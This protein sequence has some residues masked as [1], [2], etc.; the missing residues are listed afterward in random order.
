MCGIVGIVGRSPVN[1]RIYD[2]LTMLQHRGQDAAGM[3]TGD[4]AR[5]HLRKSR[6]LVKEVFEQR[7]IDRLVGNVGIGHV[8]YPTAG[9]ASAAES[10]PMYVNFPYGITLA[11]NGNLTNFDGLK[12]DLRHE[13]RRHLNTDSDSELLLNAFAHELQMMNVGRPSADD[14]FRAVHN[15]HRRCQGA[16]AAVAMIVGV[17]IVSFRDPHGIRPLV[18]GRRP[19]EWGYEH[20]IASESVAL[21]MLGFEVV[22]DVAPGE[23]VFISEAGEVARQ[24][25][26]APATHSPCLFEYV[27]LARPDSILDGISVY[28][29]RLRMGEHLAKR[30]LERYPGHDH[31]IDVV[32]PIPDTSRTCA[33]PL[34]YEL[35]V[36]YREGFIKNRY[37]GR[38]FIM[39]GQ[40]MRQ[41]SVR[42]KLNAIGLEFKGKNVLL[43]DDSIVRGTTI[44]Q[45]V[46]MAREAGARRVYV[47]SAAPPIRYPN[48]YGIDMPAAAEL[49]A[50]RRSEDEVGRL[51]HAD[52]LAY[53]HL[54]DLIDSARAGNPTITAFDCSVFNG[55]YV[56][57]GI[58][59]AYLTH[60]SRIRNDKTKQQR[61]GE[62]ALAQS[63]LELYDH[64]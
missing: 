46:Q 24:Q 27:Y 30:V 52:W 37:I 40:Q 13:D 17:G 38:T 44:R 16:Y 3:A 15:V 33:L 12:T 58:D 32:I 4:G 51:V 25:C 55:K 59:H 18:H 7:H 31:D 54:E 9:S 6:G 47:A 22:A 60:L 63:A 10:Q 61:D 8:R 2:A 42:Q 5:L 57:G 34:A 21:D 19:S 45:I 53:Q 43:V 36:K 48:V 1:Q 20:M 11:H 28:K 41:K 23:A 56:T 49:V 39:P 26:A 64:A 50:Y 35:N 14:I 29:S 62:P